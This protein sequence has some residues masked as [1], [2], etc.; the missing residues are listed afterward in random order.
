MKDKLLQWLH[1]SA[2]HGKL[3]TKLLVIYFL[4]IVIPLGLFSLYTHL[5]V[6]SVIRQQTLSAAQTAF[7]DTRLSIQRI[8]DQLDGVVDILSVD[9][10]LYTMASNDSQ[11]FT[12]IR[13]LEDSN[14][15][16]ST[17]ENLRV[18]S[19]VDRI[20]LYV[21]N[22]YS[23]ASTRNNIVKIHQVEDTAWYR[24]VTQSSDR[25]W[26]APAD[27]SDLPASEQ[28]WFSSLQL[29][30][31]PDDVWQPL[32]VI[33]VDINA[34]RIERLVSA[35]SITENGL[36]LILRG[37][38]ILFSSSAETADASQQALAGQ[39]SALP[40]GSWQSIRVDGRDYYVQCESLGPS[41]WRIA[42][43]LPYDDAYRL[44]RELSAEMLGIVILVAVTAYLLACWLTRS[45]LQRVT[46]LMQTMHT[47][48]SGN[49][50]ARL[51]PEG[52]DEI[53]Q[54]MTTFNRMMDRIDT[55]MEE[56][57]E[58]GQQIKN[59]ELK[60]LQAQIN[61]H[62]L[63]N[64][65]DLINCTAIDRNVPEISQMVNALSRFYRLSLSKGREVI[66]LSD[67]IKH[68]QLYV[69]IQNLRFEN[70]VH[71]VWQ[72]E[73][74]VLA[75]PIIKIVL[76][77]IIENAIIH[78]IFEKPSK[79]GTLTVTARRAD[80]GIQIT[81]ADDGVGMDD[82]TRAANFAPADPD[83]I[84]PTTGGYGVRNIQDRLRIAYG[85]PYGLTCESVP[86]QG[87][88]VTIFIPATGPI[89]E[90]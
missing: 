9:P 61:P 49:V 47:V 73:P 56:K 42:S 19:G 23:Y 83:Q 79:S 51:Q 40:F 12:Y 2:T 62:F 58:Y 18:L 15:I 29:V 80:G 69:Q 43:V 50:A 16:G 81:V 30:F 22:D 38:E 89:E 74:D 72:I 44:S 17:F 24:S 35:S 70:R 32:A 21:S 75:Y 33:R 57:V 77:P 64:S 4:L 86:G 3:R 71:D 13:R 27:Y 65:L 68:A 88:T 85:A 36:M 34:D 8:L 59:L 1:R 11:D 6:R 67:E 76:Q 53:A 66:P 82:A 28:K 41:S 7:E 5:R 25:L 45:T 10:L 78:G 90:E 14:Q 46:N 84:A 31:D 87:T 63:Y 39:L 20:R 60:A 55:L 54:L 26:C 52:D 37:D 48:E